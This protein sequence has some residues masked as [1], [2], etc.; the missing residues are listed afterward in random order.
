MVSKYC[1]PS[2]MWRRNGTDTVDEFWNSQ[3]SGE[4]CLTTEIR[5]ILEQMNQLSEGG[6]QVRVIVVS[7]EKLARGLDASGRHFR[8]KGDKFPAKLAISSRTR[9]LCG[10][11]RPSRTEI[12]S[13]GDDR[14]RS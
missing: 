13:R 11:Q 2:G 10:H 9:T 7:K 5:K 8:V 6:I 14:S 3:T 1:D 12:R 4:E